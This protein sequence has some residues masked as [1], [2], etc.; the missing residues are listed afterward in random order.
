MDELCWSHSVSL[1]ADSH[2]CPRWNQL[3][4]AIV[5]LSVMGITLE[6]IEI[7]A[8]LPINPTIIRI[9]R[10]LRIARGT[11][12]IVCVT[13]GVNEELTFPQL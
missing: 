6:E 9:M 8:A 1:G 3:D 5:L 4:L 13:C 12:N 10:V 7:S 2:A 11:N